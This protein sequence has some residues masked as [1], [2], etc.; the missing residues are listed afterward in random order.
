[1]CNTSGYSLKKPKKYSRSSE[2]PSLSTPHPSTHKIKITGSFNTKLFD[3]KSENHENIQK[4]ISNSDIL[5]L[6]KRCNAGIAHRINRNYKNRLIKKHQHISREKSR[7]SMSRECPVSDNFTSQF[8]KFCE[9]ELL[10]DE[11]NYQFDLQWKKLEN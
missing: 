8:I 10:E 4:P 7:A 6:L 11:N 1:M 2:I 9:L 3:I 5:R